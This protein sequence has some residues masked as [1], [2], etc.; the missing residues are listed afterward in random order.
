MK[1]KFI[2]FSAIATAVAIF[3][4]RKRKRAKVEAETGEADTGNADAGEAE[5]SKPDDSD[6]EDSKSEDN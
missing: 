5:D 2:V 4:G 6:T 1:K 3:F